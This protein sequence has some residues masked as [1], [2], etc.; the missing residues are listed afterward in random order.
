MSLENKWEKAVEN[1]EIKRRR[2][3]SLHT[4][5]TTDIPYIL[6]GKSAVNIGDTVVRKGKISVDKP[7]LVLPDNYP[8]FKGFDFKESMETN[9]ENVSS[10]LLMRGINFPSLEYNNE[11]YSLDV[12]EESVQNVLKNYQNKLERKE[13]VKTG[14]LVG[15]EDCWQFSLIIYVASLIARS[16]GTDMKNIIEKIKRENN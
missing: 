9:S 7:M 3:K 8:Q 11:L 13:N 15:P 5:K 10:F 1:T 16:A 14:L 4:F 6:L 2:L 12:V